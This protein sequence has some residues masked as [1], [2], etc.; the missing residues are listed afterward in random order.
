[1][2]A[3]L[4]L[5]GPVPTNGDQALAA[6]RA[7]GISWALVTEPSRQ[8]NEPNYLSQALTTHGQIEFSDRGWDLYRL[9]SH[10]PQPVPVAAC[11]RVVVGVPPCWG[12]P[13]TA[14]RALTVGVTRI[15][16]VCAGETLAV[17]LTQAAGGAPSPVLV[18]F[19]GGN[20]EFGIQPGGTVPGVTQRIYA[21]AP[22]GATSAAVTIAPTAGAQITS[23]SIGSLG[24]GCPLSRRPN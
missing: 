19:T 15:V 10:P 6:L 3:G 13:Q 8:L 2:V 23:A 24:R 16:P 17:T 9:V 7:L 14:G 12:G 22:P 20:P 21:T 5:H 1:V 4:E 11:D 18:R